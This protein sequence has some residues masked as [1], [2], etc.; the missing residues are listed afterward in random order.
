MQFD[1][2]R[3]PVVVMTV[4]RA[5]SD[6][7]FDEYLQRLTD[8][9]RRGP[10]ATVIDSH[11]SAVPSFDQQRRQA[12]WMND[13][14]E[15]IA[16]KSLGNAFVVRSAPIRFTLSAIFLLAK[17]PCPYTVVEST[18]AAIDWCERQL[19]RGGVPLGRVG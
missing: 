10:I 8:A 19:E 15:L 2:S 12:Q 7:E 1:E 5:M 3:W 17:M 4:D 14:R 6:A 18:E 16:S 11:G 9:I 13:T